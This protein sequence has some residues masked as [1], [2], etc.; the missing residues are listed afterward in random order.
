MLVTTTTLAPATGLLDARLASIDGSKHF[1]LVAH[2]DG[3]LRILDVDG[4]PAIDRA[5]AWERCARRIEHVEF[6]LCRGTWS[7]AVALVG[8][9][10]PARQPISIPTALALGVRGHRI[11]VCAASLD[12]EGVGDGRLSL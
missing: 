1:H 6:C 12:D 11:V 8:R 4:S 2:V 7:A 10:I 3:R 9:R 5:L